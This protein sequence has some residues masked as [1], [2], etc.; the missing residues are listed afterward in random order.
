MDTDFDEKLHWH[1]NEQTLVMLNSVAKLKVVDEA[2]CEQKGEL[3][4]FP[5]SSR[6][7]LIVCGSEGCTYY[8]NFSPPRVDYLPGWIGRTQLKFE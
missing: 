8:E 6:I 2:I 1:R 5:S 3:V 4:F 7:G